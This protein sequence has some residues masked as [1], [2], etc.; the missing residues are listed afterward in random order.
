MRTPIVAFLLAAAT[1]AVQAGCSSTPRARLYVLHPAES[2][3]RQDP[4]P[5]QERAVVLAAVRVPAHLERPVVLTRAS[6]TE[7]L[8]SEFHRWAGPLEGLIAQALSEHLTASLAPDGVAVHAGSRF[9]PG[10]YRLTIEITRFS[11]V[12]GRSAELRA[13]WSLRAGDKENLLFSRTSV[14]QADLA[15]KDHAAYVAAQSRLLG[16]LGREIAAEIRKIPA[17]ADR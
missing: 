12:L 9:R 10:D 4:A 13:Q 7:L 6:D 3:A 15:E 14:F 2:A 1:V 17:T 5:P 11:G 8:H 16:E